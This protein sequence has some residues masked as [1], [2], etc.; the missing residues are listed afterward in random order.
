MSN[1]LVVFDCDGTLV[2]SQHSI[3][4]AMTR[5][6]EDVKLTP[7]DRLAI[8]SAVGLSL[9]VAMARLLPD[10]EAD[11]HDHLAGRYKLAFQA[12]R[13][14]Q[15]VQE[16]LYPGM[17]DLVADLD[18]AGWLLG[19]AT[20]KSDRGLNLCLTHHGIID[21]FV[22]LQTADRHP[23]KPHPSMLLTAMADAGAS[24]ATTV[25]IGDTSFDIAMGLAAGVRSIGVAWGYH[26][27]GE[28]IAA[29]AHVVAM[30]SAELRGH[31]GAP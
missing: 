1:R 31:I 17:A 9:P 3:C 10:A 26:L 22:T 7:P 13:R 29:G 11:F 2:D 14:E 18:A 5:A 12:M 24:P 19:V 25:M 20:G 28:L 8:L 21:R 23:S 30:D 27:P 16:P 15:G 6:F 4:T